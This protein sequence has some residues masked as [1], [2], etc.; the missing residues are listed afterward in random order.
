M[1]SSTKPR[2]AT[3]YKD[4]SLG[5]LPRGKVIDLEKQGVKKALEYIVVLSDPKPEVTPELILSIHQEGFGFIFP[6]WAGKYRKIEVTVGD[7]IPPLPHEIP[8][9][10][11]N[12]T[13]DLKERLKHIPSQEKQEEFLSEVISLLAW[14]QNRFVWIHPF[15]DYNGRVARL[16]TNLLALS[17]G[18]PLFEIKA[19]TEKDRDAYIVAMKL[20]DK[21]DYAELEELI[22]KALEE[23]LGKI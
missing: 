21:N 10:V 12:L 8:A 15:Q 23:S 1:K 17:L 2:S 9:L 6:E 3:R 19:D 4:T 11:K 22:T 16:L 5:I 14:F 18:L 20:A 13:A 7:Y